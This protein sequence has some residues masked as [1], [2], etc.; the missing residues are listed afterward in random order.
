MP[1]FKHLTTDFII[2]RKVFVHLQSYQVIA[3]YS[4]W[5]RLSINQRSM[6]G[7]HGN[8]KGVSE[9]LS[10]GESKSR[11]AICHALHEPALCGKVPKWKPWEVLFSLPQAMKD[12]QQTS[13]KGC[14]D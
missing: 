7:A 13:G 9:I 6:E 11:K 10:S 12:T 3:Y 4:C 2:Q 14:S 8:S 5:L 1:S